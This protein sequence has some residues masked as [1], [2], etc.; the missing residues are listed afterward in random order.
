MRAAIALA[1]LALLAPAAPARASAAGDTLRV[2]NSARAARGVPPLRADARLAQAA[3]RHSRDM[4]ARRYF[5]HVSPGGRGLRERVARTGWLSHRHRW[6]LAENLG[7]GSGPLSDPQSIVD[8]WLRSPPHRRIMLAR[9]LRVVGIG[10][11]AGTPVGVPGA[12]YTADFGGWGLRA[13]GT[14]PIDG[15]AR[16]IASSD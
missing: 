8:A 11:A 7:W 9:G 4:V 13:S 15:P 1:A 5:D 16:P 12:T 3:L 14:G 6:R 10:V 2:L